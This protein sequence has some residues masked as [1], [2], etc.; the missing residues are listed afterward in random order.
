[1][2]I[3]VEIMILYHDNKLSN[4]ILVAVLFI[5]YHWKLETNGWAGIKNS[6]KMKGNKES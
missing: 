2:F 1:M 4:N 5:N 3:N 6:N